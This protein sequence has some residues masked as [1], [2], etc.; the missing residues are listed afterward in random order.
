MCEL[1]VGVG[2]FLEDRGVVECALVV[3]HMKNAYALSRALF[4][5][6]YKASF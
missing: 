3:V 1:E 4:S 2:L 6:V 5:D